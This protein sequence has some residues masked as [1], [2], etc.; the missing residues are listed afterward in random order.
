MKL[1]E[2]IQRREVGSAEQLKQRL[3]ATHKKAAQHGELGKGE[4]GTVYHKPGAVPQAQKVSIPTHIHPQTRKPMEGYLAWLEVVHDKHNPFFPQITNVEMFVS[5]DDMVAYAAKMEKLV[6]YDSLSEEQATSL[7]ER[8]M[9]PVDE[10][11]QRHIQEAAKWRKIPYQAMCV[12]LFAAAIRSLVLGDRE[13]YISLV[14]E[15]RGYQRPKQQTW[16]EF[17]S[18][19]KREE[20]PHINID[21]TLMEAVQMLKDLEKVYHYDLHYNNI[22]Y[23]RTPYGVQPVFMDPFAIHK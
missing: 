15:V 7:V 18:G 5:H 14:K 23:R 16:R 8:Y 10:E 2:V 22:L 6:S 1:L 17:L 19:K 4:Y 13:N 11:V 21:D 3:A 9:F 12:L 20:L